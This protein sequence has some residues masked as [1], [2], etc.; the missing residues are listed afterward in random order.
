ML[1]HN[2]YN[3]RGFGVAWLKVAKMNARP[4]IGPKI[5]RHDVTVQGIASLNA[6]KELHSNLTYNLI[7]KSLLI[8]KSK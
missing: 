3:A 8:I 2:T 7:A 5:A 4:P 1:S 6:L